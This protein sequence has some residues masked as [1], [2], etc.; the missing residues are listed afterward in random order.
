MLRG[1]LAQHQVLELGGAGAAQ[2]NIDDLGTVERPV[3][4]GLGRDELERHLD[5]IGVASRGADAV[6]DLREPRLVGGASSAS[7]YR[8]K[9][10]SRQFSLLSF[11]IMLTQWFSSP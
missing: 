5:A 1:P 6:Q 4:V 2:R 3:L 11:Q 7:G 8:P 9:F 10:G